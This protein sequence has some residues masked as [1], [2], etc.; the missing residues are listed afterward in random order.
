MAIRARVSTSGSTVSSSRNVSV[1]AV[2]IGGGGATP[3]S[4][5]SDINIPPEDLEDGGVLT[6]DA[7]TGKFVLEP[8]G[9]SITTLIGGT[10]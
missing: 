9:N 2:S 5:L 7:D 10:F 4:A 8:A 1:R 3:L 6:Y